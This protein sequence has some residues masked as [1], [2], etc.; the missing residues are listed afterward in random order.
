MGPTLP[1]KIDADI[2]EYLRPSE[3]IGLDELRKSMNFTYRYK[4]WTSDYSR[5]LRVSYN[6]RTVTS[7]TIVQSK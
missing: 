7:V 6:K 5:H 1:L 3:L 2:E 4:I